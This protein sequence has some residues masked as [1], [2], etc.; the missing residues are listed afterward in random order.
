MFYISL[1]V[2]K[3]C[4]N[5]KNFLFRSNAFYGHLQRHSR[6]GTIFACGECGRQFESLSELWRHEKIHSNARTFVCQLCPKTFERSDIVLNLEITLI[7]LNDKNDFLN[8]S[9]FC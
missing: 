3:D 1:L 9:F 4:S 2:S 5:P 8:K 7:S 6:Q